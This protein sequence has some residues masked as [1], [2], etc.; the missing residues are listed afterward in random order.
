LDL[1]RA[2]TAQDRIRPQALANRD[3]P[4]D[5]I[6]QFGRLIQ[7]AIS[8][9]EVPFRKA[10]IRSVGGRIGISDDT[11]RMVGDIAALGKTLTGKGASTPGIRGFER[12]WR[13]SGDETDN[14]N[15]VGNQNSC[16]DG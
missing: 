14:W 4:P 7:E 12:K 13:P 11:I 8:N 3:I 16:L 2:Q 5:L 15:L 1:D 10:Y 6:Q 9:G